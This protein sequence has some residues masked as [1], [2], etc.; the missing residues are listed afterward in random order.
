MTRQRDK[1]R[2]SPSAAGFTLIELMIA[3]VL[4]LVIM[5]G[6]VSLFAASRQSFRVDAQITRMQDEARFAVEEIARDVQMAGYFAQALVPG[7]ITMDTG[8]NVGVDCG[9]AGQPNWILS[10]VDAVTGERTA[11]TSVDN[12]TAATAAAAYSCIT[13]GEIRNNTD[14]VAVKRVI[15]FETPPASIQ[16]GTTYLRS[17]MTVNLLYTEPQVG[18]FAVPA[19]F[20]DWQYQPRI[21]FVRPYTTAGDN[22]PS[23]CRK[24][25][26]PGNPPSMETE[27]IAR[28]I[29]DLQIDFGLDTDGDGAPNRYLPNPTLTEMQDVVSARIHLL[30]RTGEID[31]QQT[32]DRTYQLGNAPAYTPSDRFHRRVYTVTVSVRNM[33]NAQRLGI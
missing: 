33:R 14:I 6:I 26:A 15:G 1:S 17:N 24:Y 11:L 28:G 30:A 5:G 31:V 20:G 7:A 8:L 16:A 13:G 19:P 12:A 9:P 10:P 29:E 21:Y 25:L 22:V 4:G 23:L 3:M 2:G 32:D 18:A 27:C